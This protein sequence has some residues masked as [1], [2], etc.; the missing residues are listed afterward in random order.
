VALAP[1]MQ[2]VLAAYAYRRREIPT[3]QQGFL[4]SKG[5]V[6]IGDDVWI[7]ANPAPLDG[8]EIGKGAIIAAGSVM[9]ELFR[10]RRSEAA[11]R[12][13]ARER[14]VVFMRRRPAADADAD[15]DGAGAWG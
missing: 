2:I 7:G 15:H 14:G 3:T 12:L 13:V 11:F 5:G 6:R 9:G 10:L 4:R 1:G 8:A